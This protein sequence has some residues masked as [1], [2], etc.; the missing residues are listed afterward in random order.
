MANISTAWSYR[1]GVGTVESFFDL[2]NQTVAEI[3]ETLDPEREDPLLTPWRRGCYAA[4]RA[5]H[6]H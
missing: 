6:S 2:D 4:I 3:L 5:A 1:D